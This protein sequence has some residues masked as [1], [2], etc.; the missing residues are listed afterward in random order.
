MMIYHQTKSGCKRITSIVTFWL[1]KPSNIVQ[2]YFDCISRPCD[3]DLEDS[4]PFFLEW[5]SGFWRLSPYLSPYQ[6]WLQKVQWSRKY[7]HINWNSE[8]HLWPWPWTE[9]SNTF[10]WHLDI[11]IP[12]W[13][14]IH[15]CRHMCGWSFSGLFLFLYSTRANVLANKHTS[16][17]TYYLIYSHYNNTTLYSDPKNLNL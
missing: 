13:P 15:V 7:P 5:Q 8:H 3:C 12:F 9:Q 17:Y 10:T 14:W 6:L 2:S 1:H 4:N 16:S 11:I